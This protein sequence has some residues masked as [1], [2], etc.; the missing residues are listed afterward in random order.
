MTMIFIVK[1]LQRY[2]TNFHK[3]IMDST[4]SDIE[5]CKKGYALH[6]RRRLF[7][8]IAHFLLGRM[9]SPLVSNHSLTKK[10]EQLRD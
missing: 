10:G 9:Y 3:V 8:P 6:L 2:L 1:Y 4:V 7:E 5:I